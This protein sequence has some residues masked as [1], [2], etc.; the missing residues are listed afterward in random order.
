MKSPT[1]SP[2]TSPKGNK[3]RLIDAVSVRVGTFDLDLVMELIDVLRE[4]TKEKLLR[5]APDEFIRL[6]GE[7]AA[8]DNLLR[9]MRRKPLSPATPE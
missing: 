7:G 1:T 3:Q 6:Q 2:T 5:C 9:M 4:E 8:Y